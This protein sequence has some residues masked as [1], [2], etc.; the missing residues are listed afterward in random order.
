MREPST[1]HTGK[2]QLINKHPIHCQLEEEVYEE[3]RAWC[4]EHG[5]TPTSRV[6]ELVLEHNHRHRRK[7]G[8]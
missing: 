3:F 4:A 7:V 2:S 5:T 8:T 1:K 6:R